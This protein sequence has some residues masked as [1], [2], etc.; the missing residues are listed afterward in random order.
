M[1]ETIKADNRK[2]Q[3]EK[4]RREILDAALKIFAE[5]GYQGATISQISETAGTSLGLLY[6][7]FPN[8]KALMEAVI[9]E[10]SFL[11]ML[12]NIL[13]KPGNQNIQTV[14]TKLCLEFYR[15][16]ENK[17]ALVS[18]FLREG[19]SN[20]TV[21]Q[22]WFGML[23]QGALSFKI[24]LDQYVERG[25]LKAHSTDISARSLM[26]AT[27]MLYLTN[28]AFGE[29][30]AKPAEFITQMVA[31]QLSGIEIRQKE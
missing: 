19:T 1:P 27:V 28:E 29:G 6:H 8:K 12:K 23:A 22:V 5:Q 4:R 20:P 25:V 15:L 24:F 26:S 10:N 18:V 30:F 13:G 14:L 3:A 9:A 17:K 2:M 7:Y 16:L 31:N 21:R 11:P